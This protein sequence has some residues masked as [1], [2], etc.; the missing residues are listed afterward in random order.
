[1]CP[2]GDDSEYS[3]RISAVASAVDVTQLGSDGHLAGSKRRSQMKKT[4][5]IDEST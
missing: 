2:I 5:G 3:I 4:W 1:M